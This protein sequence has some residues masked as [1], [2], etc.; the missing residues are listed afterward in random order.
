MNIPVQVTLFTVQKKFNKTLALYFYHI[1]FMFIVINNVHF[2]DP[3]RKVQLRGLLECSEIG[4]I[5]INILKFCR[6]LSV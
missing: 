4:M 1:T 6:Y 3:K 2:T 5:I